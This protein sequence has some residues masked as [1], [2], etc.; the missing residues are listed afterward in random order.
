M[1]VT[2]LQACLSTLQRLPTKEPLNKKPVSSGLSNQ[3]VSVLIKVDLCIDHSY[4]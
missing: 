2:Y 3:Q 1:R 4:K